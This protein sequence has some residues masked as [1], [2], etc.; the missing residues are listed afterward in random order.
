MSA[1]LSPMSVVAS[2]SKAG[3][4]ESPAASLRCASPLS[5]RAPPAAPLACAG[6]AMFDEET[7]IPN[8]LP[9]QP[10]VKNACAARGY[11]HLSVDRESASWCHKGAGLPG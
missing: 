8:T 2:L 7:L 11:G 5:R 1:G 6:V 10:M 4:R 9:P 3:I